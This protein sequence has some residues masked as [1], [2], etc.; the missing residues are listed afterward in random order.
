MFDMFNHFF[1][2]IQIGDIG[3][4][5]SELAKLNIQ[6]S[7][8]ILSKHPVIVIFD[9]E[10]PSIEMVH[11]LEKN[12]IIYLFRLPSNAYKKEREATTSED[13]VVKLIHTNSRLARIK[14]KHLDVVDELKEKKCTQTRIIKSMLPS[15]KEIAFMTNLNDSYSGKEIENLYFKR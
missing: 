13:E 1:L 6:A 7:K 9:R 11:F 12:K 4:S 14:K 15:G 5:E 10:Y 2:D 8:D 3:K